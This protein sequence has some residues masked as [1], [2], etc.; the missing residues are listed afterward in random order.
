M[1]QLL[2]LRVF[3]RIAETGAFSKAA[4]AMNIP[5]PTVTKLVQDLERHLD[6]QLLQRTTRRVHVTA[7]GAAYYERAQRLIAELEEMDHAAM[8]ARARPRGR[9]RVDIGSILANGILIPALPA[10]RARYP[11]LEIDLGVS[12]RSIDLV[13]EGVDCVI[14]GG[15]LADTTLVARRIA[16]LAWVTCASP[17]YLAAHGVPRHPDDLGPGHTVVGYFSSLTGRAQPL[18]FHR[19]AD[20]PVLPLQPAVAVNESTAHLSALLAGVGVGQVF[21]FAAAPHLQSGA[22]QAVLGDWT[23]PK[24]R[25]SIV[26]PS[27]RHLSAKTR[28]FADWVVQVFAPFDDG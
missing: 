19:G 14:R 9:L 4:D 13:G 2:A 15:V 1:D 12:D 23:R 18:A 28:A 11:E 24:H 22:L 21:R 16:D 8:Q 6:T 26:Y 20:A 10:F 7:E 5:R 17:G 27:N 25:L 3:V